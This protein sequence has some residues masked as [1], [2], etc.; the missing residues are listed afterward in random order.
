LQLLIA[1]VLPSLAQLL[2]DWPGGA[3]IEFLHEAGSFLLDDQERLRQF[4][5][6]LGSISLA[7]RLQIVQRI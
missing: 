5:V 3:V 4:L 7:R 1:H 6:A 2:N